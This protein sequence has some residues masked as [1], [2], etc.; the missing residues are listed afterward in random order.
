[1]VSGLVNLLQIIRLD[2]LEDSRPK[3]D[4]FADRQSV[5]VRSGFIGTR[6]NVKATQDHASSS[7][8]IPLRQGIRSLGK[9]EMH[10]NANHLRKRLP[11]R[12]PLQKVLVPVSHFPIPRGS[13]GDACQGKGGSE[14]VLAE[15]RVRIFGIK[16][17][18]EQSISWLNAA[19]P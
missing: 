7:T 1:M 3:L 15:T 19:R 9:G 6:Q 2:I 18:D 10:G 13:A 12:R 4:S 16:R 8:S 11:R 17:V 5:R 14:N